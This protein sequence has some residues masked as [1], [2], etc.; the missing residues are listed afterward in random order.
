MFSVTKFG[1][2]KGEKNPFNV[3]KYNNVF[4]NNQY[5]QDL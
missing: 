4:M 5:I 2:I 3:R 1:K